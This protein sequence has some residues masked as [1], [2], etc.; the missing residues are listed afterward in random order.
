MSC[1]TPVTFRA[2]IHHVRPLSSKVAFMVLRQ[3]LATIQGVLV[4]REGQVSENFVRWAERLSTESVAV[5]HG[6]L[7]TPQGDQKEVKSATFH[8]IEVLI[9]KVCLFNCNS[10][11]ISFLN[12]YCYF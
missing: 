8:Q 7:Q 11:Y 1:G 6:K 10:N 9:C 12:I 3:G 2:R 5:I 4:A